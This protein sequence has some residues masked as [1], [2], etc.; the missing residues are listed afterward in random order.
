MT[1]EVR[2][3][4]TMTGSRWRRPPDDT[5]TVKIGVRDRDE[6]PAVPTV[7]VTS[8]ADNTTLVVILGRQGT[9]VPTLPAMTCSTARAAA[10]S[11]T[12]TATN[13]RT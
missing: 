9:R 13:H 1:V 12:T 11:Q 8:P 3:G 2:D 5:I 6:P 7:T 4:L 10:P